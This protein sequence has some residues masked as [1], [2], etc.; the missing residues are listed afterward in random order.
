MES[1]ITKKSPHLN[2]IFQFWTWIGIESDLPDQETG[3]LKERTSPHFFFL[4][5]ISL[6]S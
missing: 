4:N 3:K 1:Y 5:P 2:I 6:I